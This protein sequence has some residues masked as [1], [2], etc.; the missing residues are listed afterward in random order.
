MFENPKV[1]RNYIIAVGLVCVLSGMLSYQYQKHMGVFQCCAWDGA[2]AWAMRSMLTSYVMTPLAMYFSMYMIRNDFNSVNVIQY[3]NRRRLWYKQCL[4][5]YG[6]AA[7]TIALDMIISLIESYAYNR[8]WCN[9]SSMQ[10]LFYW[11]TGSIDIKFN[12]PVNLILALLINS[13]E[14]YV[15]LLFG[16]FIYWIIDSKIITMLAIVICCFY[17][18]RYLHLLFTKSGWKNYYNELVNPNLYLSSLFKIV[19]GIFSIMII[20]FLITERKDFLH[21]EKI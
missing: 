16:L 3:K 8:L 19:I 1:F 18:N 9:Y 13:G 7:I 10:S 4:E 15:I 20:S 6:I 17:E 21:D 12:I 2:F 11:D 5:L 14:V